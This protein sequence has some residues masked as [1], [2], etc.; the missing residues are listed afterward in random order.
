MSDSTAGGDNI[1]DTPVTWKDIEERIQ[2]DLHTKAVL[3]P[4]RRAQLI[5][6]GNK[7]GEDSQLFDSYEEKVHNLHNREVNCYRI[8]SRFDLSKS[9]M[10]KLYFAECFSPTNK[11]KGFIGMEYVE[12]T[13]LRHIFHNVSV[14][15]ICDAL[16]AL[17]YLQA[18]SLQLNDEEKEKVAS[19][20]MASVCGPLLPP[21]AVEKMLLDFGSRSEAF[22]KSCEELSKMSKDL[23]N[24]DLPYTLNRDLGMKDV[25]VHGDLWSANL[26]WTRT[27]N[28]FKLSRIIDYQLSHFGCT[29]EDMTRLLITTLSGKDRRENWEKLLEKFHGYLTEYC[30]HQGVPYT[31][32]QLKESYRRFLPFAGTLLLPVIDAV[33]K[34][35]THNPS[36]HRRL[37]QI[38]SLL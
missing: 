32:E 38:S 5:G 8:F 29:A 35:P 36:T 11:V 14:D 28:G 26:M 4:K 13:E 19:N 10:P 12:N 9:K 27:P 24:F 31:L 22:K 25:M 7:H 20:P 15:E 2:K 37:M 21:D 23:S 1:F 3:G 16:K 34:T 6:D 18:V 17:A 30:D 33:A